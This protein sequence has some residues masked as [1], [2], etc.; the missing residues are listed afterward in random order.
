[1]NFNLLFKVHT[2]FSSMNLLLDHSH[3]QVSKGIQG[4]LSILLSLQF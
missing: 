2:Y 3:K 1:M 4:E